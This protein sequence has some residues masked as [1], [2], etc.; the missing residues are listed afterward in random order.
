M[1]ALIRLYCKNGLFLGAF[2]VR[3]LN[4]RFTGDK[5]GKTIE[6]KAAVPAADSAFK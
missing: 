1:Y 2:Q 5:R 3:K 4:R 6:N